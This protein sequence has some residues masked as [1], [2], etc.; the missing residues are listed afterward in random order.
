V[1]DLELVRAFEDASLSGELF[2]HTA[3][4]RVGW[5]YVTHHSIDEAIERFS[6]S[7]RGFAAAQGAA[8]KYH[9]TMTV[10]WLLII[11]ERVADSEGLAW[12]AFAA[13]HLDLLTNRP[14]ILSHYYSVEMLQ[15]SRAR[16]TFML[17]DRLPSPPG[18]RDRSGGTLA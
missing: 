14:S 5:W 1:T 16:Q 2:D 15:S 12:P 18:W 6:A 17:P 3:H 11:A 9:Q 4:V 10:A 8:E 13:R 7:L